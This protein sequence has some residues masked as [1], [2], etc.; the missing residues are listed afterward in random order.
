MEKI[1]KATLKYKSSGIEKFKF[2][3]PNEAYTY[4]RKMFDDDTIEYNETCVAVY[5][6]TA[7]ESIGWTIISQGGIAGTV[8]DPKIVITKALLS[9]AA[10][11]VLAHNHP[12]GTLK[13]SS[14]DIE[15]TKK[16]AEV[17]RFLDMKFI[18]HLIV[19]KDSYYSLADKGDM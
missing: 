18:D 12:S 19:T 8:V 13:P 9:G 4:I 5:L 15:V 1:P 14:Q 11:V 10:A 16:I 2:T 7:L 3:N 17:C 6:N